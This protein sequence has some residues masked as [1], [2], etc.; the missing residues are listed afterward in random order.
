MDPVTKSFASSK[1]PETV[2]LADETSTFS[3]APALTAT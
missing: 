1:D 3:F 2:N